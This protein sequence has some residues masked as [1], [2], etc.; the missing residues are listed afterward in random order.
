VIGIPTLAATDPHFGSQAAGIGF[1]IPSVTVKRIAG[2]IVRDGSVTNSG[3]AYLGVQVATSIT[4]SSVVVAG[5]E[6]GG[7][8]DRAGVRPGEVI[9]AVDGH[10]IAT[11][12]E[13][14]TYLAGHRPGDKVEIGLRDRDGATRTVDVTLGR[15]PA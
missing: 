6:D 10:R 9:T 2:Q 4:A 1:A 8:A 11:A 15:V 5:V 3:R 12:D 13:L 7:P 14:T